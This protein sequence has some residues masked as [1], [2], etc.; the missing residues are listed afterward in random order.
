MNKRLNNP[1]QFG[2]AFLHNAIVTSFELRKICAQFICAKLKASGEKGATGAICNI[3]YIS[4]DPRV[5]N[6]EVRVDA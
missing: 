1:I 2:V 3:K 6:K 4:P 5:E